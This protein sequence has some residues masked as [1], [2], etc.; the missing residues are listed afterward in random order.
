MGCCSFIKP[1]LVLAGEFE[2]GL[3]SIC[4]IWTGG[5][6]CVLWGQLVHILSEISISGPSL[7]FLLAIVFDFLQLLDGFQTKYLV[8]VQRI[9]VLSNLAKQESVLFTTGAI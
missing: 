7:F 1:S 2:Q 5:N 6:M 3:E 9:A 4:C 8:R